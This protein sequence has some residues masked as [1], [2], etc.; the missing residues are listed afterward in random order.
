MTTAVQQPA[1]ARKP[2]ATKPKTAEEFMKHIQAQPLNTKV[3]LLKLLKQSI[4]LDHDNL[5]QQ[6]ELLD[7]IK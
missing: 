3:N 2:R 6:I 4:G 7:S 1:K 5:K